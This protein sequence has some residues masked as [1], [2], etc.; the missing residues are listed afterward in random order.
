M[1]LSHLLNHYP[2]ST[3]HNIWAMDIGCDFVK[4]IPLIMEHNISLT[5]DDLR[6]QEGGRLVEGLG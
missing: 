4:V 3:I 1:P 5:S 6:G 2:S